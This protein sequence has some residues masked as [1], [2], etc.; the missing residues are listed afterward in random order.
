MTTPAPGAGEITVTAP[1][2]PQHGTPVDFIVTIGQ[3]GTRWPDASRPESR[4]GFL[5]ALMTKP[6]W[7]G[8]RRR[9]FRGLALPVVAHWKTLVMVHRETW[10]FL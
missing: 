2:H 8:L 5:N 3:L 10:A 9:R 4:R 1:Q 7:R 6:A